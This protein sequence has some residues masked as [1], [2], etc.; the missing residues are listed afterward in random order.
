MFLVLGRTANTRIV[1]GDLAVIGEFPGQVYNRIKVP[2]ACGVI[3]VPLT[4]EKFAKFY[5]YKF[6][7]IIAK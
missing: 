7:D 3:V 2:T 6:S 4:V 1:G 5:L